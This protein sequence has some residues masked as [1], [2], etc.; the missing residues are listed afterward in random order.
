MNPLKMTPTRS[1]LMAAQKTLD[2]AREG[3]DILDK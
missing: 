3:Y 2:F 1:N